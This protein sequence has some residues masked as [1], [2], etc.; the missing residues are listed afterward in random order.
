MRRFDIIFKK[1]T[2]RKGK[3]IT[4]QDIVTCCDIKNV[5]GK[6]KYTVVITATADVYYLQ[7]DA[8]HDTCVELTETPKT[9]F[10]I[11]NVRDTI[12]FGGNVVLTDS[13]VLADTLSKKGVTAVSC[14]HADFNEQE[15]LAFAGAELILL[16][17]DNTA[18]TLINVAS[19]LKP[20]AFSM[21]FA[22][23]IWT[24]LLD[25]KTF[26]DKH[27]TKEFVELIREF[28]NIHYADWVEIEMSEKTKKVSYKISK[29]LLSSTIIKHIPYIVIQNAGEEK[30]AFYFYKDGKYQWVSTSYIKAL[31]KKFVP[32][33]IVNENF[34]N[35]ICQLMRCDMG[36][37]TALEYVNL[38]ENYINFQNGLLNMKTF[39]LEPHTP[40]LLST[41]Q[42]N[43]EY[44]P[45]NTYMPHFEA[46]MNDLCR[47]LKGNIDYEKMAVIQ[48]FMG[49]VLSNYYV[50]RCKKA[51]LLYSPI[52]N[53]GKSVLLSFVTAMLGPAFITN[54][55]LH[56][57]TESHQFALGNLPGTRAIIDGDLSSNAIKDSALFK[58]ITG[59]DS[60][61]INQKH[62]QQFTSKY[63]GGIIIASNC[64]PV[65]KDDKGE[66]MYERM[67][68]IPCENTIPMERRD[69]SLLDK[70]LS[71]KSAVMNWALEGLKRLVTNHFKFSRCQA[72][73]R[74]IEDY[75]LTVDSLYRYIQQNYVITHTYSDAI[76]KTSFEDGYLRYCS[77]NSI[78][79]LAKSNIDHRM[80]SFGLP[81]DKGNI[82]TRRGIMIY[83]NIRE[84][85]SSDQPFEQYSLDEIPFN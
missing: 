2:E 25:V 49:L 45:N 57:M 43:C 68:I 75:R 54:I 79:G 33:R 76:S 78:T 72:S 47:D 38:N 5:N 53:T 31:I 21:I 9:I 32:A 22:P 73:E 26:F 34:I 44:D 14:D 52:G 19:I 16:P 18:S 17:F 29:G 10:N 77:M 3:S 83:R 28:S 85:T 70:L 60:L 48:E 69:S 41:L 40:D 82:G 71:E 42:L 62:K 74:I 37:H 59:G 84:K 50:Y 65:F 8:E 6:Y 39:Q 63:L 61:C 56:S 12:N 1:L 35:S 13:I 24:Q 55:P 80:Q 20:Y 46:F 7:V 27:N 67:L 64:L 30:E 11:E 23:D 58:Q 4:K 66:H 36:R 81:K 51:L 15:L